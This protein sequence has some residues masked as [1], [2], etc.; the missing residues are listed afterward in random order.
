MD[1]RVC[2]KENCENEEGNC[3]VLGNDGLPVKIYCGGGRMDEIP[4][5]PPFAKGEDRGRSLLQ[6][7]KKIVYIEDVKSV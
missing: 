6:R 1:S 2:R 3:P 5:N 7:G 4:F